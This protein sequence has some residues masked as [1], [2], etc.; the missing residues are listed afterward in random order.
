MLMNIFA[1]LV[2]LFGLIAVSYG[3]WV[4]YEPV[5]FIVCGLFLLWWSYLASSS[6]ANASKQTASED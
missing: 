4:I 1:F 2:G 3:A 6:I 5:G